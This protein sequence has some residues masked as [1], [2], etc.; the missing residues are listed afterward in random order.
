MKIGTM[1]KI[2]AFLC[3][4]TLLGAASARADVSW[5]HSG[6]V[7]VGGVPLVKF[8][9]RNDWS[10]QN[11]RGRFFVDATGLAAMGAPTQSAKVTLDCIERLDD[12]KLI[13]APKMAGQNAQYIEEPYSTLKSRLSFNLWEGLDEELGREPVPALTPEQRRRL[14]RELR[15]SISPLSKRFSRQY[16]RVLPQKRM[17]MGM[18]STGYRYT[19]LLI[20]P[21]RGAPSQTLR[22]NI[23]FWLA[24]PQDGD[25]EILGF[26]T[27]ANAL[28]SGPPTNSMWINEYFPIIYE[29][30]PDELQKTIEAM[31]GDKNKPGFGYRGTPMQVFV[32]VTPPPSAAMGIG[33][34]RLAVNLKSRSTSAIDQAI[35]QAPTDAK[36]VEVEPYLKIMKNAV[37]QG[38][39]Q[40]ETELDK[41]FK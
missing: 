30:M 13:I 2:S 37:R 15:A 16:F 32:T 39:Q 12:D 36:R 11:H 10:N 9:L 5:E 35:F 28:K 34:I 3:A 14:G 40:M 33:D 26:T 6:A 41:M 1:K 19:S 25:A 38:R 29:T 22:A 7:S 8:N 17:I 27:A 24:S 18:E 20:I 21:E 31:I 4:A 23:E